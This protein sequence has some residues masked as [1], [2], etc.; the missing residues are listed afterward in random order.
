MG[1]KGLQWENSF[2]GIT[3][4][5]KISM[6]QWAAMGRLFKNYP[7]LIAMRAAMDCNGR[8]PFQEQ[9]P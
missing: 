1:C 2:S 9:P 7:P 8:T 4:L 5:T 6:Q 3:H